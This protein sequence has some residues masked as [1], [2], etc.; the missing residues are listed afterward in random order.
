MTASILSFLVPMSA[1]PNI[2]VMESDGVVVVAIVVVGTADDA[3]ELGV[4][5]EFIETE[6]VAMVLNFLWSSFTEKP[7]LCFQK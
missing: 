7:V 2:T 5:V 3:P 6:F 4:D 1:S